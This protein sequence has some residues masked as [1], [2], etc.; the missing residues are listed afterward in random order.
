MPRISM[1]RPQKTFDYHFFDRNIREQFFI[2]GTAVFIHKY[3]GPYMN[4]PSNCDPSQPNYLAGDENN[5]SGEV[6]ET[7]IQDLLLLENRDRKYDR[8]IY[9][10][11]GVYNVSDNDFDLT[12]FNTFLSQDTLYMTFHLNEMVE[13]IGRKLMS[14]D[15]LELPHLVEE[16]S[17]DASNGPIP[18]FYVVQDAN[19]AG[20]GFSR[21]WWP[22]IWRVK[23]GPIK[24]SQ[25]FAGILGDPGDGGLND[26][27]S[28]YNKVKNINDAVVEKAVKDARYYNVNLLGVLPENG[29]P[30]GYD[31]ESI[32]SGDSFPDNPPQGS[33]F[34]RTDFTPDRLFVRNGSKWERVVDQTLSDGY[35]E[36]TT[37]NAGGFIQNNDQTTLGDRTFATRQPISKILPPLD[38]PKDDAQ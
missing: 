20:E 35:W 22:H 28:I 11:R 10:L 38:V 21:T 14:G 2:G 36:S 29:I 18:R 25:E 16:F 27:M 32:P 23:I 17:L 24:D 1:W 6:N 37:Y 4:D 3:L 31:V 33:Y 19:R 15:V 13:R 7:H 30:A 5:I 12:Q 9:E 34:I 8:D 26:T